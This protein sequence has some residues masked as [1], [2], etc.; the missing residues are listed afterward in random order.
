MEDVRRPDPGPSPT[1]R[2]HAAI[3]FVG[4]GRLVAVAASVVAVVVG[5]WWLL[6]APP[7]PI[8][9]ELPRAVAASSTVSPV[10][11]PA[12][13]PSSPGGAAAIVVQA[14]GAVVHPGVYTLPA[15]SRVQDLIFAAGGAAAGADPDALALATVLV[16]GQRVEVPLEGEVVAIDPLAPVAPSGPLDLN[17]ATAD[18]LDELPGVGPSTAAAIVEHRTANGPFSS[19]EDLLD[20]RGIGPAKLDAIRDAVTL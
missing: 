12:V 20:V 10:T 1:E 17:R 9:Q 8:E 14:A 2:L 15:G 4:I 3:E 18:Q 13:E 19:I 6:H 16:D 7:T 11:G 5:G